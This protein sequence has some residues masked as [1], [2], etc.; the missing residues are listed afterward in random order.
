ML[1]IV[2][3]VIIV[4]ILAAIAKEIVPDLT[5]VKDTSRMLS[6][7]KETQSEAILEEGEK[8]LDIKDFSKDLNELTA[9]TIEDS[10]LN[11]L[12]FDE[13]GRPYEDNVS[14]SNLMKKPLYIKL[15]Y[16]KEKK[17]IVVMPYSGL[18]TV[19]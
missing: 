12:C 9:V 7:I 17:G 1:E 15:T 8:C 13:E 5:L 4:G 16:K 18:V 19:R 2:I 10:S 14:M 11:F 3:T 6:K